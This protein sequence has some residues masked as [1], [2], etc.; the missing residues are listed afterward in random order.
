[1]NLGTTTTGVVFIDIYEHSVIYFWRP[2]FRHK[3]WS[4]MPEHLVTTDNGP[5]KYAVPPQQHEP[6]GEDHTGQGIGYTEVYV[7]L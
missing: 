5:S 6:N 1:M 3:A 2:L 4:I 7:P